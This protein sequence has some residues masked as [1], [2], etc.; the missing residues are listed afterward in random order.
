MTL[1]N[2][3]FFIEL[4][5]KRNK[6][7]ALFIALTV[8]FLIAYISSFYFNILW[9][10]M[11]IGI[12][13]VIISVL[14]Y[15]TLIYD[16]NKLLKFYNDVLN[17]IT[18]KD[19]YVFKKTDEL[20]EHDGVRLLRLICTFED[21]GEVFERTLYFLSD[22][23]HPTLIEGQKIQVETHRNIIINIEE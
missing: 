8:L 18:Q 13:A 5:K 16:K 22:I 11:F 19:T 1:I 9:I 14:Y 21:D 2:K 6:L 20:T 10:S 15:Y 17:G 7:L 23:P 12:F 4:R 3:D